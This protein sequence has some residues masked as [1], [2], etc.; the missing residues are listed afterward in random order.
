LTEQ[1]QKTHQLTAVNEK[2]STLRDQL[3][4]T[5]EDIVKYVEKRDTLNEHARTLRQEI[6]ELKK[7][8]D[9]L[10][11][12]VKSLKM[13]RD[14]LRNKIAPFIEEI[15]V[16]SQKIRDL[17]EKRSGVPRHE[18]QKDFDA[19]EWKIQTTSLDLKEEKGLIEQVKQI[20]I[21][22]NVYKKIDLQS[23]R[24]SELKAELKVYTD[25]ADAFHQELTANAKNSQELHA[26]MQSKFD[27][28]NKTRDEASRLHAMYLLAKEQIKPLHE[29]LTNIW[30]LRKRLTEEYRKEQD[31]LR[32]QFR[33]QSETSK[34]T[35]ELE[36]KERIGSQ[37]KNKLERGEKVDWRELQLLAGDDP[38]DESE[39]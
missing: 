3:N 23:K 29:E 34:K 5:N 32:K 6:A 20:E 9:S 7:E 4:K 15:K 13:Q 2:M 1:Q 27:E 26:K 25:K 38:E 30:E 22:L 39:A 37:A 28:M 18:L 19:I 31:E 24:I 17:K 10:N 14:E 11:E 33:E 35:K 12:S 21:Q 8:R 16:H 36:L